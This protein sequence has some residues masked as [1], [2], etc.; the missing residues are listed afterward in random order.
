MLS[1]YLKNITEALLRGDA[2][3]ESFY[4][5]LADLLQAYCDSTGKRDIR[6]TSN[7]KKT[8]AGNPDFRVW[9]GKEH[10]TGYIEAKHPSIDN[11]DKTEDTDQ[12]K[13]YLSTFPNVILTNFLEFRLYKNKEL[14]DKVPVCR[15]FVVHQLK[16]VPPVENEEKLMMLLDKYFSFSLPRVYDAEGLAIELA[17]RTR[18]M[19]DEVI[20]QELKEATQSGSEYSINGFY[21]AFKIYL[22]SGLT[23]R[24]FADLYAQT[25][26]YGL[27]AARMRA[28]NGFNRRLA[29]DHI[30][31]TIGI[32]RDIFRFI[33]L[34][35]IPQQM[36]WIL[37]DISEVLAV[38]DVKNILKGKDPLMHF[39]EPFLYAYDPGTRE[40]RGVY[41]TPLPVVSYIVRSLNIILKEKFNK[42]DGF[43]SKDVTVLDP[44]AGTLTFLAET[45]KIAVAEYVSKW[46]AGGREGFIRGHVIEDFYAFE[47]MMAPYA[48]GHL[49]MSFILEGLGYT[50]KNDERVKLYLTNTLEMEE[51]AQ[52]KFPFMASLSAESHAAGEIKSRQPILV[53]LGNPPYS[54][55]SPNIGDWIKNEIKA[56][57]KIDGKPLNERNPKWLQDDYVKFIRFAEWKIVQAGEGILGFIT[58]HSY[59]DN[60]TFRGMRQSLMQSF[61]DI[62]ILDLH[63]NNRKKEKN[64]D[65]SKDENVFDIQQGVAM[66][67]FIKKKGTQKTVSH[68]ELWGSRASKYSWLSGN[69]IKT[70]QW[71]EITPKSGYYY[72]CP[73]DERF[74]ALYETYPKITEIFPIN[75][76]GIVTARDNLTIG[77]TKEDVWQTV[78]NFSKLDPELARQTYDLGKDTRDWKVELAQKD[79]IEGGLD[80]SNLTPVL[81]RPFD[82]RYTYYTGKSRG[83]ICMPR[84][85]VMRHMSRGFICRPRR[86]VMRHM[87]MANIGLITSRLTK[88]KAFRHAYVTQEIADA[89]C[90]SPMTST[91][92]FTFP[93]YIY[94]TIDKNGM[95]NIEG[96]SKAPNIKQSI[97]DALVIQYKK[98]ISPEDIFYYIYAVLYSNKYRTKYAEF[99]RRDFPRIPFTGDVGIFDQMAAYG[100]RLAE[101][102][103]LQSP[104]LN[105]PISRFQGMG[106]C[107]VEKL[108]YDDSSKYVYI[109]KS[110]YFE[111]VSGDVWKYQIGGYQVCEKWLKDRKGRALPL[112]EIQ[113]YCR[114]VTS[115]HE[116]IKLQM[117][118]DAAFDAIEVCPLDIKPPA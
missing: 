60:P 30:P 24:E 48:V 90:L 81:Y 78:L 98:N 69:D 111:G 35:D 109:N 104:E 18:F 65:G 12:L 110:Q 6:I 102:H 47:L 68:A 61:D 54:G 21:E 74:Y 23:E 62:Y 117:E 3:E 59:L 113:N 14:T 7:P 55:H 16:T 107:R 82:V 71:Q 1:E 42:P 22:I 76:V 106:D 50:L 56:Y 79:L 37:D 20:T 26:T 63:G 4:P 2:R 44:S 108:I 85:D 75:S 80:R 84:K 49:N 99:L 114:I 64:P 27:F 10:I 58:N 32:L 67:I 70:T 5:I 29:Y 31:K 43:A 86:N 93:L 96:E 9:D 15:P 92:G 91:N 66:A 34:E 87:V 25:I 115:I 94:S 19:R 112:D 89:A 105:S 13:R 73:T 8:E 11:L 57:H 83:F 103:L 41:Y 116:T 33:S 40:M 118:I 51:L 53:I 95:Y 46:G 97:Y 28:Q 38:T 77:W 88:G 101:L 39:Y 52:T 45:A 100:K 36:E 72:F 17:G